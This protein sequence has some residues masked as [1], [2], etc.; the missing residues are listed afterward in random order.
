MKRIIFLISFT[1]I[2][3]F[4]CKKS[5]DD[6]YPV[7]NWISPANGIQINVMDTLHVQLHLTDNDG[8]NSLEVKL[9]NAQMIQVM[10]SVFFPLHGKTADVDFIYPVNS[11]RLATGSYYLNAQLSD[12]SNIQ[13]SYRNIYVTAVPRVFKGFFAAITPNSNNFTI[14]KTDTNWVPA[15]YANQSSDFGDM[16]VSSYWQQLYFSGS[17]TGNLRAMSLDGLTSGFSI[18]PLISTQP[19]WGLMSTNNSRLTVSYRNDDHVKSL[20]ENGVVAF[21]GTGDNGFYPI[22]NIQIGNRTYSEQKDISSSTVKMVV[23]ISNGVPLQE[24]LLGMNAVAMFEKDSNDVYVLG[25][26][27]GQG[28]LEIYDALANGLWEPIV[29]PAGTVT[30]AA[31]IDPNTLLIGMSDGTVYTFTYSPVGLLTWTSGINPSQLRYNDVDGKV[32]SAEGMNVKEYNY[33]PFSLTRTIAVP[34]S[35][36]DLELWYNR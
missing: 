14:Y 5:T 16:E 11:I 7:V 34:D 1:A 10:P 23:Y 15:Q 13:N 35:V 31:E 20:D 18:T 24:T 2:A 12:G 32:F 25:N 17:V 33:N 36:R 8:L 21:N 30:S 4:S 3:L 26:N 29:L 27:A 22:H 28:H 9:V 19:Y 6:E